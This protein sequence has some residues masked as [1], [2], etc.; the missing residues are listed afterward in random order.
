MSAF[1]SQTSSFWFLFRGLETSNA[2]KHESDICDARSGP[3]AVHSGCGRYA[4]RRRSPGPRLRL[5]I[6]PFQRCHV[7]A[8]AQCNRDFLGECGYSCSALG[9]R[10]F[11]G[12]D[13]AAIRRTQRLDGIRHRAIGSRGSVLVNDSLEYAGVGCGLAQKVWIDSERGCG[14]CRWQK[15]TDQVGLS[16]LRGNIGECAPI[17]NRPFERIRLCVIAPCG[18]YVVDEIRNLLIR[19]LRKGSHRAPGAVRPKTLQDR[20]DRIVGLLCG[21]GRVAVQSGDLAR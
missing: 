19:Q 2:A 10:D 9:Q 21:H 16:F 8:V 5:S 1:L 20:H 18:S 15:R 11:L 17:P 13:C 6:L 7:P 4:T 3:I 12:D 14:D